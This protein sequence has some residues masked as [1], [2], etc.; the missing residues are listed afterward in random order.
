M[1]PLQ[2][3]LSAFGPYAG[4][5]TV[6][7]EQLGRQ[8]LYLITGDTGAGKTTL[9]DAITY[10]LY[11]EPSGSNRD[12]SMFRSEYAQTDTPTFVELI[13]SY[14]GKTYTVRRNPEYKR[15]SKRGAGSVVQKADAE[16][17]LPDGRLVTKSR[18]VTR[19]I[20]RIIGL[21]RSQFSQ[22]AMIAQGDFLK[23]LLA[24]T[25]SR[26]EIFRE[27]FKTRFYMTF[28]DRVKERSAALQKA[29]ETT[30]ASVR[31]YIAGAVCPA[32]NPL[33]LQ[34]QKA[35]AGELPFQDT[36][37]LLGQ[38]IE[39]DQAE[40]ARQQQLLDQLEAQLNEASALLGKAETAQK[41][42]QNLE[43]ATKNRDALLPQVE[44][45]QK[46]LQQEQDKQPQRDA[47][48]REL[49]ALQA[50]RPQ[51][52]E[53]A[54]KETALA[55]LDQQI[56]VGEQ[57]Q[58][59]QQNDQQS[60]TRLLESQKQELAS[61]ADVEAQRER[62]LRETAQIQDRQTALQSLAS[63]AENCRQKRQ[64]IAALQSQRE[65]L[66]RQQTALS[67]DIQQK[68]ETLE[69]DQ[70]RFQETQGL[71]EKQE[72]LRQRQER[73]QEKQKA[74]QNLYQRLKDCNASRQALQAAQQRYQQ[75]RAQEEQAELVY[76][77]K[78]RAFLDAQAG[79]LAQS[80]ENGQPCPVCGALHHPQPAALAVE[81][82]TEV[83]LNTAKEALEKA[84]QISRQYSIKAGQ[85]KT[86]LDERE[87]A[88][89]SQMEPLIPSPALEQAAQQI[90]TTS[91]EAAFERE[92]LERK[93]AELEQLIA[94]RNTLE[95]K[96]ASQ[97]KALE[98]LSQQQAQLQEK[99]NA[100]ELSQSSLRGQLE[101]ME[102]SLQAALSLHLAGYT[103]ENAAEGIRLA[104]EQ[105]EKTL[106]TQ[107]KQR[108][109]LEQ[110]LDHKQQL[111]RELPQ[112]EQ[113]LKEL[114]KAIATQREKLAAD[115]SRRTEMAEQ[116]QALKARLPYPE[117][118]AALRRETELNT[119]LKTMSEALDKADAQAAEYRSQLAAA[120]AAIQELRQLLESQPTIDVEA[121]RQRSQELGRRR[122]ETA[123]LQKAVHARLTA[124]RFALEKMQQQAANLEKT[125]KEYA[126]VKALSDTVNG[127]LTG[128]E[129]VTLET[130]IQTTFFDRIL[131]RANLR[132]M[133]MSSGQYEFKR[134]HEA[135]NNRSL[136]GLEL[137]VLDYYSNSERSAK[138]LSGGESF[139]A[140]LSLAL[141]MA[142]EV[143]SAA[144]GIQ[145]DTMFV[146]E[147]FG[148]LDEESLQQAI[149]ALS[150]L[151][152]GNRLVGIISHVAELKEKIDKQIVVT[153]DRVHGSQI[154]IIV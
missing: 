152:D 33:S 92:R 9:F 107:K 111:S 127:T 49:A 121:Q 124:N 122:A 140:S 103:L 10:A 106:R 85:E 117:A 46:S 72:T 25:K 149:R 86:A 129:K 123:Q 113:A 110:K 89:L 1:R 20:N 24:D 53:L 134:Q 126:W 100:V 36:E 73:A 116:I 8:G 130:Y 67:E 109:L 115:R 98:K 76:S 35:Q 74:I 105:A 71:P 43:A 28:Q 96:I 154:K 6:D 12:P 11:G 144:G 132:L 29:C 137:N 27:I 88:L 135:A 95:Q 139:M 143:Q 142:D 15:P 65:A 69:A 70:K 51:Y 13:F 66:E 108:D 136:S 23:L 148:S 41:T 99:R 104:L 81:A 82:P 39:Q 47:F 32:E 119:T 60:Q 141:G 19:E 101:Q 56:D 133:V 31:Q 94:C 18:E 44:Q 87:K 48:S 90:Q 151:T 61:L 34:L 21:D 16:L 147:G 55:A 112:Q 7:L 58:A 77:H 45:A 37:E 120:E 68:N 78:N 40:E 150:A 93:Q 131:Q 63:Q 57:A 3:T 14:G 153:K 75:A 22:I 97:Q 128:Q 5:V 118:A 80:L 30:R 84:R 38:L 52:Q 2:L 50:A 4:Q 26:Q 79:L 102:Q 59:R 54:R 125:E 17:R 138:S 91:E 83:E 145:L 146:D 62:L 64:E 114:E 42:R